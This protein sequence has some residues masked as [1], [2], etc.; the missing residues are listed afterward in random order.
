M[1]IATF[2]SRLVNMWNAARPLQPP[3]APLADWPL[4]NPIPV[5]LL[6]APAELPLQYRGSRRDIQ[7]FTYPFEQPELVT[8]VVTV[9][10]PDV[11]SARD[12]KYCEFIAP[13]RSIRYFSCRLLIDH[14]EDSERTAGRG[15]SRLR[16]VAL[17]QFGYA[18]EAAAL[19]LTFEHE[20]GPTMAATGLARIL[21]NRRPRRALALIEDA[22]RTGIDGAALI[23]C[24][25]RVLFAC[26]EVPEG[27]RV[28]ALALTQVP[29]PFWKEADHLYSWGLLHGA[30]RASRVDPA[31]QRDLLAAI[32]LLTEP[33]ASTHR[34]LACAELL[35]TAGDA[36]AAAR[37]ATTALALAASSEKPGQ[38]VAAIVPR[39]RAIAEGTAHRSTEPSPANAAVP[40]SDSIFFS[41]AHPAADEVMVT[42]GPAFDGPDLADVTAVR[43]YCRQSAEGRNA[44]LVEAD[45]VQTPAG[46]AIQM[47]YKTPA[48]SGFVFTGLQLLPVAAGTRICKVV[49]AETGTTGV[50]E[51]IVTAHLMQE[52]RLTVETYQSSWSCDP[53]DPTYR[54]PKNLPLRFT[55]DDSV[56]DR[57]FPGHPLT[58]VRQALQNLRE[59]AQTVGT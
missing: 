29:D 59:G 48:G 12:G 58:R 40:E 56:Y 18:E 45:L 7:V 39:A 36:A 24:H 53:Y 3:N 30:A 42:L 16:W 28:A 14:L 5:L 26:G 51:A 20:S 19:Y 55:S 54:A 25:A 38:D 1:S 13:D 35:L 22:R 47:I 6:A 32:Q 57:M 41:T 11:G 17:D 27:A 10:S 44:A 21:M 37:Q 43:N 8:L 31:L 33:P 9:P 50:R 49:A 2:V 15:M 46:A 23:A 4:P 52:G 34:V